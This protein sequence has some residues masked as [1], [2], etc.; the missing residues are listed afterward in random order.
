M[1][2][3]IATPSTTPILGTGIILPPMGQRQTAIT[4]T[5][6]KNSGNIVRTYNPCGWTP[7]AQSENHPSFGV[8]T[9]IQM[10][11]DI[12]RVVLASD[13]PKPGDFFTGPDGNTYNVIARQSFSV[14]FCRVVGFCP[15]LSYDLT[16]TAQYYQVSA[17]GGGTGARTVTDTASGSP[18]AARFEPMTAALGMQ[19]GTMNFGDSY[20]V[21]LATDLSGT[22]PTVIKAGD[23]FQ[24]GAGVKYEIVE[25][26]ER[27]RLDF[28]SAYHCVKKL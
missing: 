19:F 26:M 16:D 1:T 5:I 2:T 18:V 12:P 7:I 4:Y 9:K 17:S 13:I 20:L 28:L 8:Y 15:V 25:V 23:Y 24:N 21:F 22:G 14:F 10:A 27:A 3:I 6:K 11:I